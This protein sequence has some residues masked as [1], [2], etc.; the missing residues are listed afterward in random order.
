MER[1]VYIWILPFP[2]IA[3]KQKSGFDVVCFDFFKPKSNNSFQI[4][5]YCLVGQA[6]NLGKN[7]YCGPRFSPKLS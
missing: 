4:L 1:L 2:L 5:T 7:Q 6:K 3:L